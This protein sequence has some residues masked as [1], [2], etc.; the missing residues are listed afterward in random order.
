[1]HIIKSDIYLVNVRTCSTCMSMFAYVSNEGED[2]LA[3][4]CGLICALT[5]TV[6]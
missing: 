6:T 4:P 2:E 5:V 3:H 1:M